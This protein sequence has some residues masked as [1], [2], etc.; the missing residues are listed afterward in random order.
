V[1]AH[2]LVDEESF[3]VNGDITVAPSGMSNAGVQLLLGGGGGG[4]FPFVTVTVTEFDAGALRHHVAVTR[5][6]CDPL[7]RVEVSS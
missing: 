1:V 7:D 2:G 5:K 3:A 4:G 6:V